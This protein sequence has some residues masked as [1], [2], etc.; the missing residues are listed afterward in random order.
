MVEIKTTNYTL[1]KS[2]VSEDTVVGNRKIVINPEKRKEVNRKECK[3]CSR[4]SR[5]N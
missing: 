5:K 4:S 3:G 1:K 2:G